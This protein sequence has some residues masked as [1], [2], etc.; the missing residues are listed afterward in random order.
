MGRIAP[1][2]ASGPATGLVL[3]ARVALRRR[4]RGFGGG[5]VNAAR[6]TDNRPHVVVTRYS[7]GFC[8]RE[9]I[10]PGEKLAF[11][12]LWGPRSDPYAAFRRTAEWCSLPPPEHGFRYA[13][14][15]RDS[16]RARSAEAAPPPKNGSAAHSPGFE[17]AAAR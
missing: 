10:S 5:M 7:A 2:L 8:A 9:K 13:G 3:S 16:S 12:T 4:Y 17:K 14:E 6:H 15:V 1:L 11:L